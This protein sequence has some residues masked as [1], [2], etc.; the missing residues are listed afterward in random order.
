[1]KTYSVKVSE[2]KR[3]WHVIDASN[4]VLGNIATEAAKLL[5]GKHKPIFSRHLDT[6][7][8]VIII[9]AD[10]LCVTGNKAKQKLYYRHS[11]YAGGFKSV[12]LEKILK[13]KPTW[14]VEHAVKGMLPNNR[15]RKS[16]MQKLKVYVGGAHPH[17]SQT[18][19]S[20]M[21]PGN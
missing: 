4:R 13:T 7:D 6:G 2:I 9:H 15:L 3:E 17:L 1:M 12:S 5:M 10:K 14:A 20:T 8:F 18:K 16:M 19:I 21:S 11:G